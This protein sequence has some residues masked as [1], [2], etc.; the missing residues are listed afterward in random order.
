MPDIGLPYKWCVVMPPNVFK[1]CEEAKA[2]ID[3]HELERAYEIVVSKDRTSGE[4]RYSVV[5]RPKDR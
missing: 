4:L 3:K 5:R 1:N 2:F